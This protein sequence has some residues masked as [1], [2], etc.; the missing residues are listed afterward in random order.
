MLAQQGG[1]EELI[2]T[3]RAIELVPGGPELLYTV[4]AE[5]MMTDQGIPKKDAKK[6]RLYCIGGSVKKARGGVASAAEKTR[7]AGRGDDSMMLHMSPEEYEAITAMWG[8]P[9]VNPKTGIGE[10]GFLSK[11]W[12]KIKKGVKKIVKSPIFRMVAPIALSVFMPGLGTAIGLKMGLSGAAASV[13]GNAIVQGGLG[14]VT[15]GKEGAL[16]G[17]ISGGLGAAA[18]AYGSKVGAAL[19]L[20]AGSKTANVVGSA[21]IRGAGAGLTG[22]DVVEGALTGALTAGT[23]P[24][25]ERFS[26]DARSAMGMK[27][28]SETAMGR[29]IAAEQGLTAPPDPGIDAGGDEYTPTLDRPVTG[30]EVLAGADP[31]RVARTA[32]PAPA[33]MDPLAP[34]AAAPAAA[35]T[36]T[37]S[38]MALAGKYAIPA[39]TAL[40]AASSGSYEDDGPPELPPEWGERL[41]V[42]KM[43]RQFRGLK[44]PS[45][46]FTYGQA[47]SPMS[48]QHLFMAPEPFPGDTSPLAAAAGATGPQPVPLPPGREGMTQRRTLEQQGWTY[49]PGNN[50]MMPPAQ[51][52]GQLGAAQSPGG[53]N[54]VARGGYQRGGEFDYWEQNQDVPNAAPAVS[55][56]GGHHVQGPGSGRSDDIPAYLSDG[57]YVIDAESVS[58]LGDGSG[59]EGARRLDEMR[60]ELRKHKAGK[61]KK[62][63]FTN[64]AK[65]PRAYMNNVKKLRRTVKYEHGGLHNVGGTSPVPPNRPAAGGNA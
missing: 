44:D 64:K 63:E 42:F 18:G 35:P 62:G 16:T 31:G 41:P 27:P 47:G 19:G 6:V 21:V 40:G 38:L 58:L 10:Y 9:E 30:Q 52:A 28:A 53:E 3:A 39:M 13:A 7:A 2:D 43:N 23:Q 4:A 29:Y 12:K 26:A 20:E 37:Q 59:S 34:T 24:M 61:M 11:V 46:Y 15:G 36:R 1:S 48:G 17:A 49:N 56:E 45:D 65:N 8:E 25:S 51:A 33:A 54:F 22:G 55:R 57:E 5:Q 32:S 50:S 60:R 14:A